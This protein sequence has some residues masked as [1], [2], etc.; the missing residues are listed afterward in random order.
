[1]TRSTP[2]D[3]EIQQIIADQEPHE[4]TPDEIVDRATGRN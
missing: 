1:M 4:L 2:A 3:S